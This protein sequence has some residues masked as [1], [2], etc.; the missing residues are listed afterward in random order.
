MALWVKPIV[1]G[2]EH[3]DEVAMGKGA[4]AVLASRLLLVLALG[5]L[6]PG[7]CSERAVAKPARSTPPGRVQAS[8]ILHAEADGRGS[9]ANADLPAWASRGSS[10]G[11]WCFRAMGCARSGRRARISR[12]GCL[13]TELRTIYRKGGFLRALYTAGRQGGHLQA[14]RRRIHLTQQAC[15]RRNEPGSIGGGL[16]SGARQLRFLVLSSSLVCLTYVILGKKRV[17]TK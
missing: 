2:H 12:R 10:D 5:F 15:D 16:G 3:R 8:G 11:R 13:A 9:V 7:G 14:P 17:L 1:N 4:S 6:I